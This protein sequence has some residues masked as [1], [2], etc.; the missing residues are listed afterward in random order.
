MMEPDAVSTGAGTT[1]RDFLSAA[2]LG[3]LSVCM[4]GALPSRRDRK[5]NIIFIMADDLGYGELGCYGNTFN[6]TPHL[7]QLAREGVRFT[8]AYA[9]APVCSPTRASIMTGLY[10]VRTG[11]TTWLPPST[12]TD[13]YLEP[14][15]Y[16]TVN[17]ALTAA[18][19]HTGLIG[20]WHLDT[21]FQANPGSPVRHGWHEVVGTE[22]EYIAMGDYF[23]PYQKIST[24]TE[25]APDEFLTDRLFAEADG[26]IDRNK[27]RPFLLYL[28]PYAVHDK[29]DAPRDRVEKYKRKYDA[30]HGD[31]QADRTWPQPENWMKKGKPDNPW[32]AAMLEAI[33]RGVGSLREQL[34]RL[35]LE[36]DTYLVFFSDN[37]G[38]GNVA[39]NGPLRGAKGSHYEGGIRVPM[40]IARP[41]TIPAGGTCSTPASSI[42]FYPTFCAWAGAP[43]PEGRTL[44]GLDLSPT[45]Q[46][47]GLD[48]DR[49]FWHYAELD[50]GRGKS[51]VRMGRYK[52]H[53]SMDG[54]MELY[55][56][57]ADPAESTNLLEEL[58]Q[59]AEQM[60][61]ILRNWRRQAG[62]RLE[63]FDGN[64]KTV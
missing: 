29:L 64:G 15:K 10:P 7:D 52:Y 42:D 56:L 26:F 27:D 46:G 22:T 34:K 43:L 23:Y 8:D 40:I 11:I 33:D 9:A 55:D 14:E 6:E 63:A 12:E 24:F 16:V 19:Y 20:K 17:E 18:G 30:K 35:D 44:D 38:A 59:K 45:L 13:R 37:G 28:A 41:G 36:R 57:Q 4:A 39:N 61:Q 48:R 32:L 31:G 25:G 58:P 47:G 49:L 54:T 62:G 60:R 3:L 2:G 51:A 21:D 53:E 50:G 5:P 1:R